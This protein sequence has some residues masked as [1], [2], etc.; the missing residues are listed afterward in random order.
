MAPKPPPPPLSFKL[1]P[2]CAANP[3]KSDQVR[4]KR[5]DGSVQQ[6]KDN[7][8]AKKKAAD[9]KITAGI[10]KAAAI[11]L[12][13]EVA[14]REVDPNHPPST[15]VKK[16]LRQRPQRRPEDDNTGKSRTTGRDN[17]D[18]SGPDS[19]DYDPEDDPEDDPGDEV[20]DPSDDDEDVPAA[21][22]TVLFRSIL[23]GCDP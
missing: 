16:V 9:R 19:D 15:S 4:S 2:D 20:F 8:V 1:R 5:P 11:E 18:G 6:D 3:G 22:P 17:D 13:K 12:Q 14:D 10:E 7:K 21:K 23:H